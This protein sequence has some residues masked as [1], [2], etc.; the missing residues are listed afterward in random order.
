MALVLRRLSTVSGAHARR[1]LAGSGQPVYPSFS[2]VGVSRRYTDGHPEGD[3]AYFCSRSSVWRID[4]EGQTE[5]LC[6]LSEEFIDNRQLHKLATHLSTSADGRYFLLDGI[7]GNQWFVGL[8]DPKTGEVEIIKEL[9]RQ[10]NHGLFSPHDPE[11]F[12]IA[13]DHWRDRITGRF[14]PYDHRIWLMDIHNSRFEPLRPADYHEHVTNAS[15]EWWSTDGKICWIDYE[16]GAYECDVE[17]REMTNVWPGA[18]CHGHCD[19]ERK[20]W[21]ADESPYK[22]DDKPC[23]VR[24]LD[25]SS[26]KVVNI[27]SSMAPPPY[28]RRWYH[29]DPHPQ[30]SP[31]D[32]WIDYTTTVRGQ[33]DVAIVPVEGV[34]TAI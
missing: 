10:H 19:R 2:A 31:G 21:C 5:V 1:G 28:P 34:L 14:L 29:T 6:T 30:F 25:R 24:F 13:Q 15:H 8:G 22:W 7:L 26:G 12:L 16:T 18:L 11:L 9:G 3:A 20:Y 32:T 27:V 17:T 23:E 33:I 4:K